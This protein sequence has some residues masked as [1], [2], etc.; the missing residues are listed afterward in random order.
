MR[1]LMLGMAFLFASIAVN[2]T[3]SV[4]YEVVRMDRL[5]MA[6][7]PILFYLLVWYLARQAR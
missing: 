1:H 5:V 4:R 3:I 6:I 7:P 2:S